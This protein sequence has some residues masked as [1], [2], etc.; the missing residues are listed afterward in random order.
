MAKHTCTIMHIGR[1]GENFARSMSIDGGTFG[2]SEYY[3]RNADSTIGIGNAWSI[4]FWSKITK[5]TAGQFIFELA[6]SDSSL[7]NYISIFITNTVSLSALVDLGVGLF[8]TGG[9]NSKNYTYGAFVSD[10]T[11]AWKCCLVTWNG[12]DLKTYINGSLATPDLK[13]ADA[14][15]TLGTTQRRIAYCHSATT[16]SL[17]A[18]GKFGPLYIWDTALDSDDAEGLYDAGV[19][20]HA[21]YLQGPQFNFDTYD[22]AS[23]LI[24]A[25]RPSEVDIATN[26]RIGSLHF[27]DA[28]GISTADISTDAP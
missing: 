28:V 22:K 10:P 2:T 11:P 20:A 12:T 26:D 25:W 14:S 1:Y 4:L 16:N 18:L 27:T 19:S 7:N 9:V 3:R 23:N 24:H 6:K 5:D 13:S 17:S 21:G 15:I 8:D